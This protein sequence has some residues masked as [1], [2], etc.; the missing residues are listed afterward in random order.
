MEGSRIYN[1]KNATK[2]IEEIFFEAYKEK[3]NCK[4]NVVAFQSGIIKFKLYLIF[5]ALTL[6]ISKTSVEPD[7]IIQELFDI[8]KK[9]KDD[10]EMLDW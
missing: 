10:D 8:V 6:N 2:T 1:K 3:K 7:Q 9:H 5:L 4:E